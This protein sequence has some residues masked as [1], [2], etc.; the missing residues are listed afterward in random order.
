ME[1]VG[2]LAL[3][4]PEAAAPQV[5]LE[6]RGCELALRLLGP[7]ERVAAWCVDWDYTPP[8]LAAATHHIRPRRGLVEPLARHVYSAVGPRRIAVQTIDD[9]G[10]RARALLAL[11]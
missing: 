2:A 11:E 4:Q 10:A 7:R 8:V 6:Q 5:E 3:T 1:E 9:S